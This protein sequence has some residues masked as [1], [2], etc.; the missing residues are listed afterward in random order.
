M[1]IKLVAI[2][3][4][5]TLLNSEKKITPEVKA[6]IKKATDAGVN[7]VIATGR[8]TIGIQAIINDLDLKNKHSYSIT[9]NGAVVKNTGTKEI[10]LKHA[11]THDDYIEL[12]YL[13][14]KLGV[15]F[16]VQDFNRMY[17]ANRN[18]SPY[19]IN[20]ASITGIP[21]S[22]HAPDEMTPEIEI[23]KT[24]M[25]DEPAI[26]DNAIKQ[27]PKEY[28]SRYTIV[29]SDKFYLEILNKE[30]SKGGAVFELADKLGIARNEIMAI[31]D[32]ENDLSMI[33]AAGIGV[34]MGNA[35]PSV[36]EAADRE[37]KTNDEHGVA[38]ALEEWVL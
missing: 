18:I 31:G 25:I 7:I 35:V 22:Y 19:T 33:E 11:M 2:D 23:I 30:A 1:S 21:L 6:A 38:F 8:P 14:R 36:K 15:H 4:D 13:S 37:T 26:L 9:Y 10:V 17:T 12:E 5:G 32:N 20:E 28:Y 27:I 24:M 3:I 34:A 16:H 29:K